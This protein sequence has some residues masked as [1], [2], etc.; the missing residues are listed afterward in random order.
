MTHTPMDDKDTAVALVGTARGHYI[1][2][3][4]LT[5]AIEQMETEQPPHREPSNIADMKLLRDELFPI[6]HIAQ[7][8]EADWRRSRVEVEVNHGSL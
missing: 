8:A 7:Q 1:L 6:F 2:S 4:A 5:I 3:E